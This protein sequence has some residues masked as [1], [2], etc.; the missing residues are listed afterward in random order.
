MSR[1][2]TT[3]G[4]IRKSFFWIAL[5]TIFIF[6]IELVT[7]QGV[8]EAILYVGVILLGLSS[9]NRK[10]IYV[11]VIVSSL[12]TIAG[13]FLSP[14]SIESWKS[15]LNRSFAVIVFLVVAF[16]GLK[17]IQIEE[18]LLNSEEQ[19]RN[20]LDNLME[21]AQIIGFD[22]RY[23]YVNDE[24]AKQGRQTKENLIGRTMMEIY[25][26]IEDTA[27]Y[28]TIKRCMEERTSHMMENEFTY[29][30]GDK[31]WFELSIQPVEEGVFI[32][33]NDITERKRNEIALLK[34]N[35]E[36]ELRIFERTAHLNLTNEHLKKELLHR[37]QAEL[38]Y[39]SLFEQSND[40]VFILDLQG[41]HI[42]V[43][44]H[45]ADMLGYTVEEIQQLSYAD[46]STETEKSEQVMNRLL[47]GEQIPLF[48]RL[49]RKKS[50]E[51]FPVEINVELVQDDLGTP[52]H[53]QSIVRDITKRK[54]IEEAI[55]RRN[56][57]LS[58]LHQ[59]TLDLL[60]QESLKQLLERVVELST[61]FLDANYGE[62]MFVENNNLIVK[63]ATENAKHLIGEVINQQ[64]AMLSWQAVETRQPVVLKD[65]S[66]WKYRRAVYDE[67]S[68]YAVADFPILNG[69]ECL[70]VLA[71]G[72][73]KPNYEFSEE[74]IQFGGLF[75]SLTAL[76]IINSQL[77]EI[78]RQRSIH[79]S[80]TGL[81]NRR[82]M[83]ETLKQEISRAIR[84]KHPLGVIMLDIDH[85]KNFND[86]F[87]HQAGDSLLGQLG[88]FLQTNIRLEDTACRYGGEEFLLIMPNVSLET[89]QKRAE[90]LREGASKLHWEEETTTV[91]F[92]IAIY[93]QHGKDI[94]SLIRSADRA[95]YQA[96][97]NGRNRVEVAK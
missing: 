82:Y 38:R 55:N 92:G 24:V 53:I 54:K 57:M 49:F 66:I 41:N 74:Q 39:R 65:Y 42:M 3:Q 68:L 70:G 6:A 78:L 7:P 56:K 95:L 51:V 19:Y 63:S 32:L 46:L 50:G 35:A 84:Q 29:P 47:A 52:L 4:M 40:A 80:L 30:D 21:G 34:L 59:I 31:G 44:H 16:V 26:G 64:E 45:A 75:A 27:V 13:Y 1:D 33:S 88:Q 5:L 89:M 69:D 43:N 2:S 94:E 22:W 79:D 86:S 58:D 67:I 83:E 14:P 9:K 28:T 25:P 23:L 76:I 12:L 48:E 10:I 36:L 85:F 71:L 81:F 17:R 97:Q 37:Q 18:N 96:K 62:I 15:I 90:L 60:K 73:D 91:S 61:E 72:R 93:P 11:T 87:G 77:G 8:G 20:V